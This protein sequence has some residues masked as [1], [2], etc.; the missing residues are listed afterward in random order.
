MVN[1]RES[2]ISKG[3]ANFGY[4]EET[5]VMKTPDTDS[6]IRYLSINSFDLWY[7]LYIIL[8]F[9]ILKQPSFF[10]S[11]SGK[12]KIGSEE[13]S[14]IVVIAGDAFTESNFEGCLRSAKAAAVA[15]GENYKVI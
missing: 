1:W 13:V 3:L 2:Q 8:D 7:R 15:I 11:L 4:T 9:L 5:K 12:R 10:S 6:Q 14:G